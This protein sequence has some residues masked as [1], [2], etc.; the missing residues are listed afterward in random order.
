M[1]ENYEESFG[2]KI[3]YLGILEV[4]KNKFD[5]LILNKIY[6]DYFTASIFWFLQYLMHCANLIQSTIIFLNLYKKKN[7]LIYNNLGTHVEQPQKIII[8]NIVEI[9]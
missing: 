6:L 2:N 4:A 1:K 5:L 3:L 7:R 8:Q 9:T